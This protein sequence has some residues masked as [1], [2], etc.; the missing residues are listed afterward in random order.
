VAAAP[1]YRKR[2]DQAPVVQREAD[3]NFRPEF[4]AAYARAVATAR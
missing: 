1:R 2:F 3:K 4:E